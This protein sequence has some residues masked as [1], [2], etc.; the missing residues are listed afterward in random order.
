MRR[1]SQMKRTHLITSFVL[2]LILLLAMVACGAP[3]PADPGVDAIVSMTKAVDGGY[4]QMQLTLTDTNGYTRTITC[5]DF[6]DPSH[7]DS[8]GIWD[9]PIPFPTP[10]A[11]EYAS[12]ITINKYKGK[13][14]FQNSYVDLTVSA[15][16]GT[17]SAETVGSKKDGGT[18]WTTCS[19]TGSVKGTFTYGETVYTFD[20]HDATITLIDLHEVKGG[21]EI[22]L[23]S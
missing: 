8:M 22:P 19:G 4:C 2:A 1:I 15:S 17:Y 3:M 23:P 10:V 21:G 5:R 12:H 7:P 20:T 11:D 16:G 13:A 9:V 14:R 6:Y 18:W